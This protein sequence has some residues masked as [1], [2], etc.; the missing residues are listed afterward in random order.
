MYKYWFVCAI[1]GW[2]LSQS[3]LA[4]NPSSEEVQRQAVDQ[5]RKVRAKIKIDEK[6]PGKPALEIEFH[7]DAKD[8][9]P[10][11]DLITLRRVYL[12]G[13]GITVACI[14]QLT[15]LKH[16]ESLKLLD[17]CIGN[18]GLERIGKMTQLRELDVAAERGNA[19]DEGLKHFGKLKNL[20]SLEVNQ[21]AMAT[22][23]WLI[24]LKGLSKLR[25]LDLSRMSVTDRGVEIICKDH[26]ELE[27]FDMWECKITDR[28]LQHLKKMSKLRFLSVTGTAVTREAVD[29]FRKERPEVEVVY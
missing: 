9:V 8:F 2:I 1:A 17:I 6:A 26:P 25:K 13:N 12:G 24:E 14:D 18:A 10:A 7:G 19:T 11:Q 15:K 22:D 29:V 20:Q 3:L 27:H 28:C 23:A 5:L 21:I 16:L 4:V